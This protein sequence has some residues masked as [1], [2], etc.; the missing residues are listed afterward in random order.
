MAEDE[1]GQFAEIEAAF[2]RAILTNDAA[3]IAECMAEDWVL[4]APETGPVSREAF[5]DAVAT[6]RL[7]H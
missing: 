5:L 4:V 1:H 2:N 3:R 7:S 6:G